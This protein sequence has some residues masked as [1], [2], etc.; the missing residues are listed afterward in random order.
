MRTH[1][2]TVEGEETENDPEQS[3]PTTLDTCSFVV[4]SAS[5]GPPPMG[6]MV[7]RAFD[8]VAD[9]MLFNGT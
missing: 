4:S 3:A 1:G 8:L 5:S 2:G 9:Q 6:P 7:N